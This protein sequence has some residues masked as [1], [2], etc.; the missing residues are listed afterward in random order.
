M[1]DGMPVEAS[2]G[3]GAGA[4]ASAAAGGSASGEDNLG[5]GSP[6]RL[7]GLGEFGA[8]SPVMPAHVPM[9]TT[10]DTLAAAILAEVAQGG[11]DIAAALAGGPSPVTDTVVQL[12][13]ESVQLA[14]RLRL[15]QHEVLQLRAQLAATRVRGRL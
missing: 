3:A 15:C 7:S 2:A 13:Q 5:M 14:G 11:G 9:P 4:G 12:S 6:L 8:A 1:A 10:P